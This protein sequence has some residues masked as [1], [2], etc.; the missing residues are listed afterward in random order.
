[1]LPTLQGRV[2]HHPGA[3]GGVSHC[4]CSLGRGQPPT[5]GLGMAVEAP[6]E[7]EKP[8]PRGPGSAEPQTPTAAAPDSRFSM[9]LVWGG[10]GE[11]R[12]RQGD[13]QDDDSTHES[14]SPR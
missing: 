2:S 8:M 9:G 12:S 6:A 13:R 10:E 3:R 11:G 1:M 14:P 7:E 4:P 5:W